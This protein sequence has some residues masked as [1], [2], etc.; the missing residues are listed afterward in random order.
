M[1]ERVEMN[2]NLRVDCE[3]TAAY[4]AAKDPSAM[5]EIIQQAQDASRTAAQQAE[6]TCS[7]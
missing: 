5:H 2:K 7:K 3:V 1:I 6:S 4:Q